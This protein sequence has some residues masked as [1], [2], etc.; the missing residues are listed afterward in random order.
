M[1]EP[2]LIGPTA[3]PDLHVMSFNVR[4]RMAITGPRRADHWERR[5]PA[6]AAL[7][8]AE[9]PH[10]LGAQEVLPDQDRFIR[11]ALGGEYRRIGRGRNANGQGEGCPVY[12]DS[13]RLELLNWTQEALSDTPALPGSRTW[14]NLIPR[15]LVR[16]NFR[17]SATGID[18]LAINTHFDHLSRRS[19]VTAASTIRA[20]VASQSRPAVVT[21]DLNSGVDTAPLTTLFADGTLADTWGAA[22]TR[23]TPEWGTFP[24]YREPRR[25]RKRIDWIAVSTGVD[26]DRIGINGTRPDGVWASDHLPVQ[27]VLRFPGAA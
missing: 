5:A 13:T 6:L 23:L 21:G 12:F 24:N 9:R 7:L 22:R 16:A 15:M 1:T 10:V 27:A 19:R 2:P 20:L 26:V 18:F 17:D 11:A 25:D 3:A 14:G 4:R 8:T